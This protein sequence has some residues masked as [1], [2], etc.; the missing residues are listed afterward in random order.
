MSQA[1]KVYCVLYRINRLLVTPMFFVLFVHVFV[2]NKWSFFWRFF[3]RFLK[4]PGGDLPGR[5]PPEYGQAAPP[6]SGSQLPKPQI[7]T[8]RFQAKSPK[9]RFS[10][11]VT[12][13]ESFQPKVFKRKLLN[14][15]SKKQVPKRQFQSESSY[16]KVPKLV[17]PFHKYS[18]ENSRTKVPKRRHFEASLSYLSWC[19]NTTLIL[20]FDVVYPDVFIKR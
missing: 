11:Q 6:A 8:Q 1:Q 12:Q 5:V 19:S 20:F 7:P 13:N 9:P 10:A 15:S 4:T 18:S 16:A 14:A 17:I 3:P 2:F